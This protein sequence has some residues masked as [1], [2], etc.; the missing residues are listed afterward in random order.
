MCKDIQVVIGEIKYPSL[1]TPRK[2][3][4]C[5]ACDISYTNKSYRQLLDNYK[6]LYLTSFSSEMEWSSCMLCHDCFFENLYSVYE[7]NKNQDLPMSFFILTDGEE[8]EMAFTPEE[9]APEELK[10]EA[11]EVYMEDFIKDILNP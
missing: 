3:V 4:Q 10:T 9:L 1:E 5:D 7:Q 8:I 2:K 6:I 11:G